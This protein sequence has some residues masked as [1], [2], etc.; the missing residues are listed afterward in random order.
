M[1]GS[2]QWTKELGEGRVGNLVSTSGGRKR[3]SGR[4]GHTE[5]VRRWP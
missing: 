5:L 4:L 3:F 2:G 1:R